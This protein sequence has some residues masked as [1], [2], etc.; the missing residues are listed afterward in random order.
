M[1]TPSEL[2]LV[3]ALQS[4]AGEI[5]KGNSG[6]FKPETSFKMVLNWSQLTVSDCS[7]F[8][9]YRSLGQIVCTHVCLFVCLFFCQQTYTKKLQNRFP[10]ILG[11]GWVTAQNRI[12]FCR[13]WQGDGSWNGF[14]SFFYTE[15]FSLI[16]H[17][18]MQKSSVFI[19][20]VSV[21]C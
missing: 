5:L 7:E 6:V 3:N 4:Q 9:V 17:G 15:R 12:H 10:P 19:S 8:L 21:S 18:I 20:L 16:S 1:D 14:L 13:F 2:G 11:S